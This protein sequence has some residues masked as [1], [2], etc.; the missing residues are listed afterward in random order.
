MSENFIIFIA[1]LIIT[2]LVGRVFINPLKKILKIGINSIISGGVIYL[3]N[4]ISISFGVTVGINIYT[5]II[6]GIL[7]IPGIICLFYIKTLV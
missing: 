5:C 1:I 3:I 4:L 2:V 7:G 6:G